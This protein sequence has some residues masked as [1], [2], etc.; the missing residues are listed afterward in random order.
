MLCSFGDGQPLIRQF[1]CYCFAHTAV[2]ERLA[3]YN[4]DNGHR[5]FAMPNNSSTASGGS[6]G[7]EDLSRLV[8]S[9][10]GTAPPTVTAQKNSEE[11]L[12]TSNEG[13]QE[14]RQ[15]VDLRCWRLLVDRIATQWLTR[16]LHVCMCM[17]LDMARILFEEQELHTLQAC[18]IEHAGRQAE[19]EM[20]RVMR[21]A[22]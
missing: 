9:V 15:A 5:L 20:D 14:S 17:R 21:N 1:C 6:A 22:S 2:D 10:G 18:L 3:Q 13:E 4:A 12:T 11:V 7:Q 16:S 19:Q 8:E